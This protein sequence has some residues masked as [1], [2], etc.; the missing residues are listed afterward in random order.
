[1]ARDDAELAVGRLEVAA[2]LL[3][4]TITAVRRVTLKPEIAPEPDLDS[5]LRRNAVLSVSDDITGG[6]R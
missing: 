5:T 3:P 6:S 1:M 4:D 2:W